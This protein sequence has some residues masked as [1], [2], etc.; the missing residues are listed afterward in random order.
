[1]SLDP[2]DTVPTVT[3]EQLL[4]ADS[5]L[6]LT[7]TDKITISSQVCSH[8]HKLERNSGETRSDCVMI[9]CNVNTCDAWYHLS[10]IQGEMEEQSILLLFP[11]TGTKN[12]VFICPKCV[13]VQPHDS[14]VYRAAE[15]LEFAIETCKNR[16]YDGSDATPDAGEK[17]SSS[18]RAKAYGLEEGTGVTKFLLTRDEK[19]QGFQQSII[20]SLLGEIH[21]AIYNYDRQVYYAREIL[22][23]GSNSYIQYPLNEWSTIDATHTLTEG[24]HWF[25]LQDYTNIASTSYQPITVALRLL[26]NTPHDQNIVISPELK[27]LTF[28]KVHMSLIYWFILDILS[29]KRDLYELPNMEPM[30]AMMSAVANFGH[31][32]KRTSRIA[33]LSCG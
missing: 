11:K 29:N 18:S 30:R 12:F 27:E 14:E 20:T 13:A 15:S 7:Q 31:A 2:L 26:L 25:S 17:Y 10:C 6:P 23:D 1:V 5:H 8:C 21:E 3:K 24:S 33:Y 9:E 32:S 19:F 16:C 22:C 28:S 4:S